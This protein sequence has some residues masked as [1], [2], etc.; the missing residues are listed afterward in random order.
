MPYTCSGSHN[1]L[2]HKSEFVRST[3]SNF[4]HFC[5]GCTFVLL[6]YHTFFVY[7]SIVASALCSFL[8]KFFYFGIL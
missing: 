2:V 6:E 8:S 7:L 3:Y 5:T 4:N 1:V